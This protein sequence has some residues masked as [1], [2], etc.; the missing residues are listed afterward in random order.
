MD[1]LVVKFHKLVADL[2][3][4]NSISNSVETTVIQA[5]IM[6]L[7]LIQVAKLLRQTILSQPPQMSWPPKEKELQAENV[8]KF[9]PPLL[10]MF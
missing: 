1:D 8:Q 2:N 4:I 5:K 7:S 9:I 10:D 3:S 6:E